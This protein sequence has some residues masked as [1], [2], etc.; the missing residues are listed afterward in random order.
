M[1]Y[2][3]QC[4]IPTMKKGLFFNYHQIMKKK[5]SKNI[6]LTDPFSLQKAKDVTYSIRMLSVK[7]FL[8]TQEQ[9]KPF[10]CFYLTL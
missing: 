9:I 5:M 6:F 4:F 1:Y 8:V 2:L 10:E 3:E 7:T